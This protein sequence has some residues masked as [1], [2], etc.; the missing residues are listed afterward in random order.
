MRTAPLQ[1]RSE[2][3]SAR[4]TSSSQAGHLGTS[5]NLAESGVI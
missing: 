3:R 5:K 4:S 2:Q 1:K